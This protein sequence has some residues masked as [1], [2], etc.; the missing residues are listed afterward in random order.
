[1]STGRVSRRNQITQTCHHFCR[2]NSIL[3]PINCVYFMNRYHKHSL[4][5]NQAAR[6]TAVLMHSTVW[7]PS[8]NQ[9]RNLTNIDFRGE[10]KTIVW[11]ATSSQI[12][13]CFCLALN[14]C[15]SQGKSLN[16]KND[17]FI[18]F[19]GKN[20][21][22]VDANHE[23]EANNIRMV[24]KFIL[25]SYI[26]ASSG[27]SAAKMIEMSKTSKSSSSNDSFWLFNA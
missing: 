9:H 17:Y 7:G 5:N 11:L 26:L 14:V 2:R 18:E 6:T 19:W 8:H 21:L 25:I 24:G 20:R 27:S 16:W 13:N 15:F 10:Q 3:V 4:S 12:L 1:M 22:R 23:I